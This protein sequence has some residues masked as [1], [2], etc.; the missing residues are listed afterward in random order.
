MEIPETKCSIPK[1]F[2]LGR[3]LSEPIRVITLA[4]IRGIGENENQ[5]SESKSSSSSFPFP[6]EGNRAL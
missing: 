6:S 5:G 1:R 3:R 2:E 4:V